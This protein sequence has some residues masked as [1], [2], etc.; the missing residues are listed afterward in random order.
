MENAIIARRFLFIFAGMSAIPQ[1][2]A[3]SLFPTGEKIILD[4]RSPSEFAHGH[5]PGARNL[6]L[7][8]DEER[9]RVG[10]LYKNDG[11]EAALYAGLDFAG[12]RLR[13]L[14]KDARKIS[15]GKPLIIHC[16]RGGMRSKSMAWLL[17]FAGLDVSILIGGYKAYRAMVHHSFEE[18]FILEIIGGKTGSGKTEVLQAMQS[19][20]EQIIDLEGLACHKGSAFGHLGQAP[21]PTAEQFEN[22]LQLKLS[23]LDHKKRIWLEDE[24]HGIGKVFIPLPLWQQMKQVVILEIDVPFEQRVERLVKEY[25]IF[26]K[27]E[28]EETLKKI[29][30]RLGGQHLKTALEALEEGDLRKVAEISLIYYDKAYQYNHEKRNAQRH[31]LDVSKLNT[32]QIAEQLVKAI[33]EKNKK[34]KQQATQPLSD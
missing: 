27:A 15:A 19:L 2:K 22:D 11:K 4:V 30:K 18:D 33:D 13:S 31:R 34:W 14:V 21:Q 23:E 24:N 28:L 12:A 8:S 20:G 17:A 9:A 25:G 5:I 29:G 6:P 16:W 1:I 10:T 32:K 3:D 7:F 26:S